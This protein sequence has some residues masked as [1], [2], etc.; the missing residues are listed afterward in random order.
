MSK[1]D[2]ANLVPG[3][4]FIAGLRAMFFCCFARSTISTNIDIFHGGRGRWRDWA[5]RAHRHEDEGKEEAAGDAKTFVERVTGEESVGAPD[6]SCCVF[7]QKAVCSLS[8]A[9]LRDVT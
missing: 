9:V 7:R 6:V 2:R 8:F 1:K 3:S 5:C 4:C